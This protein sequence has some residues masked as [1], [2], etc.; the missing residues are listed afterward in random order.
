MWS[1]NFVILSCVLT[2]FFVKVMNC[3]RLKCC[4]KGVNKLRILLL[5]LWRGKVLFSC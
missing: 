5:C 4:V 1:S 2:F 3:K